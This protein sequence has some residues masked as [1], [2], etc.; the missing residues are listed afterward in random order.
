MCGI[1]GILGKKIGDNEISEAIR[2]RDELKHRG[3]DAEGM[4]VS[5]RRDVVLVH[6]RLSILDLTDAGKQPMVSKGRYVIS[7]SYT[8]LRAHET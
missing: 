8:H 5:D 6:R 7:V 2:M 4:W 1:A 3:P